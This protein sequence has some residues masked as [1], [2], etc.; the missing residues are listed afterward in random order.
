MKYVRLDQL[1][2]LQTKGHSSKGNQLK[3]RD[4]QYWYKAD[5][6]GYEG[7]SEYIVS[8][9]LE[10]SN[11]K[12]FIRY[13][14]IK[15]QCGERQYNGCRSV[16]FL[17]N[18]E[19]LITLEHLYRQY[20]GRGLSQR[21]AQIV[22]VKDRVKWLAETVQNITGL[23]RFGQYLTAMLELDAFFFNEDRHTNN[24]AVIYNKNKRKYRMCEFFDH[25]L[26][27]FA[28]TM[29]DFP[30]E[31]SVED[32]MESIESKPFAR[33]FNEQMDA[34]EELYGQ[35]LFFTFQAKE[36]LKLLE[37]GKELYP[38]EICARVEKVLRYQIRK[39]G[40]F[41]SKI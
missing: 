22:E 8:H 41:F 33:T 35:Q 27:L 21:L 31:R 29:M 7:L 6:M 3:V 9:L 37:Q 24:I 38:E 4:G 2:H 32:C 34:A 5:Y 19:N 26:S 36:A 28:D 1:Y 20:T 15:I 18:E 23:A 11:L 25:G 10:Y 17:E 39:Y 13:D 40:Y 14:L 16:H 12:K 30:M